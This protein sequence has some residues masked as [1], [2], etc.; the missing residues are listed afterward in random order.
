VHPARPKPAIVALI[1]LAVALGVTGVTI[2]AT[3]ASSPSSVRLALASLGTPG[4]TAGPRGPRGEPGP[5][6]RQGT[7]GQQG[8]RGQRGSSATEAGT[9]AAELVTAAGALIAALVA[10]GGLL[11]AWRT[12]S[13]NR[14]TAEDQLD[15]STRIASQQ[16]TF[17]AVA[18]LQDLALIEHQAVMSA[19]LRAG[20]CP[21][22]VTEES[23]RAM[24][25][26]RRLEETKAE[27]A[28]LSDS[29]WE[30]DRKTVLQI[31]A[32]PN[33]LEAL[34]DMYNR[35]LLDEEVAKVHLKFQANNFVSLAKWWIEELRLSPGGEKSY[36][37]VK[38]MLKDMQ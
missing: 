35:K 13:D 34:A 1:A 6:G 5:R 12:L 9:G 32:F 15:Q 28:R 18:R 23:W 30:T 20:M 24:S 8:R 3:R 37:Q 11:L 2:D 26:E 17:D 19:F 22:S 10:L 25:P 27:W 38:E 14:R 21:P 4:A 7:R 33:M 31:L 36:D 16:R 29:P